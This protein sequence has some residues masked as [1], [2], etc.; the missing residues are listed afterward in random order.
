M[1]NI[2]TL[3][4]IRLT[5]SHVAVG[6]TAIAAKS[7]ASSAHHYCVIRPLALTVGA[8]WN[9]VVTF[10]RFCKKR[11]IGGYERGGLVSDQEV[12][13]MLELASHRNDR[14]EA[15]REIAPTHKS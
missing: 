15:D 4:K 14:K 9:L 11:N 7:T 2:S 8:D 1:R 5:K 3:V 6:F 10:E 12:K 13:E